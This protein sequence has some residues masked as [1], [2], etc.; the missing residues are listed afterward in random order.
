MPTVNE[1]PLVDP[2]T[3]NI[4]VHGRAGFLIDYQVQNPATGQPID[5]S[6]YALF[7]EIS[8][9][10]RQALAAGPDIYT[11]TIIVEPSAVDA[12][13]LRTPYAFAV[14][15][16]TFDP[17]DV[18]W[19]GAITVYG[20]EGAPGGL[21]SGPAPAPVTGPGSAT[22][23]IV[24]RKGQTIIMVSPR[25][26]AGLTGKNAISALSFGW[27]GLMLPNE[28]M[29][30]QTIPAAGT[31]DPAQCG[32]SCDAPATNDTTIVVTVAGVGAGTVLF[33][34]GASQPVFSFSNGAHAAK[35]KVS[36]IPPSNPD[37]TLSGANFF[38]GDAV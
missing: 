27:P 11:R 28:P 35:A 33:P 18:P 25:G 14:R 26:P 30:S 21:A 36:A 32:G 38:L 15:D 2:R 37:P 31:F 9:T 29:Q 1:T 16:E 3:G 8:P 5:I 13:I 17:P 4:A 22:P 10:L 23:I 6:G 20:F 34:A 24:S 19:S 12:L 7:F